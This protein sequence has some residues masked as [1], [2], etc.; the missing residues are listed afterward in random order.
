VIEFIL[1][2][3]DCSKQEFYLIFPGVTRVPNE[4][5]GHRLQPAII[6]SAVVQLLLGN[7]STKVLKLSNLSG[8]SDRLQ[9][10]E[11]TGLHW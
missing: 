11:I 7:T 4:A 5:T 1:G 2:N 9:Q 10:S 6:Y 8:S 3:I